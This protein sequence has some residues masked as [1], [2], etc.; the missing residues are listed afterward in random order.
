MAVRVACPDCNT[1]MHVADDLRGKKIKCKSCSSVVGVPPDGGFA[2]RPRMPAA[3]RRIVE[4]VED[5]PPPRRRE[6]DEEED[7]R[8]P[9]RRRKSRSSGPNLL[10]LWIGGGALLVVGLITVT[11]LIIVGSGGANPQPVNNAPAVQ[12]AQ[13]QPNA[14]PAAPQQA[15]VNQVNQVNQINVVP[16]KRNAPPLIP[17]PAPGET[18]KS[19]QIYQRLLQS[20]VWIVASHKVVAMNNNRPFAQ[21]F[22]QPPV[23]QQPKLPKIRPPVF[24]NFPNQPGM[25][26]PGLNQPGLN[27]PGMNQPGM[28]PV[29]PGGPAGPGMGPG[30]APGMDLLPQAGQQSAL[31]NTVWDGS[32]TLPG[33][34]K[35]RFQFISNISVIMVDAQETSRGNYN[36]TGNNVTITFGGGVVYRGTINGNTMSGNASNG[37]TNWTW[38]VTKSGG[39]AMPAMPG[40][41]GGG[42][43]AIVA[44]MSGSGSL[45]D[46]KHRLVI[47]NVHVVGNGDT[48]Q[49]YFPDFD[50]QGELLVRSDEY[51][52]KHGL[53]GRV[54]M[55]EDR[56]D[57]ALVQLPVLPEGVQPLALAKTKVKAAAQ[58]H[59]V[60]NPGASKSLWIY[61][62]GKVRS[63]YKDQWKV[64]DD[65]DGKTYN[66]DAMKVETDSAI[67]PGD[68]GGP[69]VDDRAA[70]V[71]VA[72]GQN[73]LANNMSHFIEVSEVRQL[74]E[75]YY[76][77][78]ND[79]LT[80]GPAAERPQL[81]A[82]GR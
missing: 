59:S 52:Q 13:V 74:L 33:F 24:P 76:R 64:L 51:K 77:S 17:D 47:T 48:V 16:E 58:V 32:E 70:L 71:G 81:A 54:V 41:G 34:G 4:E 14:Q 53:T 44:K 19:E 15:A 20:T 12:V 39:G 6:P 55:R 5:R 26:Q 37:Q 56:A 36:H 43:N 3:P 11:V 8:S 7:R 69:L 78:V 31:R 65:L 72:H 29:G 40:P 28:G 9:R 42:G 79:T 18:M 23:F 35:L 62:P 38:N 45:I 66:Y 49:V 75:K 50:A 21:Q 63:V 60:G 10:P 80:Q 22:P 1:V 67:N 30:M 57:L 2:E 82:V 73:I 27:Q 68:S 25:N 46:R 61:S